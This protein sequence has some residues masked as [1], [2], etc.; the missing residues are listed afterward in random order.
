[1]GI[2]AENI[3]KHARGTFHFTPAHLLHAFLNQFYLSL[4][5]MVITSS[6]NLNK[7]AGQATR[8]PRLTNAVVIEPTNKKVNEEMK[9]GKRPGSNTKIRT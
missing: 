6:Y 1:M 2:R 4:S 9:G 3:T 7:L 5:E 8:V